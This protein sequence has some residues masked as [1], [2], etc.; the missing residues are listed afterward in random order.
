MSIWS[1]MAE[2][3]AALTSGEGLS[4]VFEKL[5]A[6]PDRTVGFEIA[7]IALGAKMA[8]ALDPK[9]PNKPDV[10]GG[11]KGKRK[12]KKDRL[13]EAAAKKL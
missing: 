11:V 5:R 6:A 10:H 9:A 7:V 8:K 12:S 4:A 2:A 3:I 1:R 13:R